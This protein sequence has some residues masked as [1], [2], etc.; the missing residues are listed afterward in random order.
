MRSLLFPL[1]LALLL[2]PAPLAQR[3]PAD[4]GA[5]PSR[6]D[7]LAPTRIELAGKALARFPYFQYTRSFNQGEPIQIA[8]DPRVER[9][10]VRRTLDV[11]LI[12]HEALAAHLAGQRFEGPPLRV[13]LVSAL[14]RDNIF[15]LDAGTLSGASKAD[16]QGTRVLGRGYDLAVDVDADGRLGAGDLLDGSLDEAGFYVLEDFVD[17]RAADSLE[18]GPYAVSEVLFEGGTNL[19]RQDVYFP[20]EIGLLGALPLIVVSHGN[21]HFYTWYDHIGYHLASWGYVVMSHVNNTGP[22]IETAS[23]TTLQNTELFFARLGEIADG[24]L[25]G[26]VDVHRQVWIGH[27]RGG[28]GVVRAYRRLEL[29]TPLVT[30][31]TLADVKLVSSIAPTD[32]LGPNASNMGAAS[33]HLWTGGADA[34][35]NGCA[36]C[37]ICQTFHLLERAD[38]TRFSSS[39]H[40]AGHGDFHAGGGSSVAAGPCLLGRTT[41]HTIMRALLLPLVQVA[42]HANPAALDYLTRQWEEFRATGAPG[43]LDN[44]CVSVDLQYV[45]GPERER[46]VIDDFQSEPLRTRSSSGGG[47][48][49]SPGLEAH[50]EEGRFDDRNADF[51]TVTTDGMNGMTLAGPAD[52]SAG[53]VFDWNGTDETLHFELIEGARDLGAWRTLSFRGAQATRH[54][55]TTAELGDLDFAVQVVDSALHTSTLQLSAYGA[56]LEEPYQRG[57]CGGGGGVGW[58]NEFETFRIPLGDFRRGGRRIDLA[59]VIG[60]GFLFGPAHGSTSGRIGLDEI[61]LTRD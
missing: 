22:G 20:R 1:P 43:P 39:L 15:L 35:V 19:T 18:T 9:A 47:V 55:N 59:N 21:G 53:I 30:Q 10:L 49:I 54:P 25:L 37:N 38:G 36:N 23:T 50:Y 6:A 57:G 11:Y 8:F 51:N 31:Y 17:F 28:E 41:T 4:A 26:H 48:L 5:F 2:A 52:D 12:E 13:Q 27:S 45:P 34:D 29:G 33:Y 56:G 46:L 32:F 7:E 44:A 16:E 58:G 60:I 40:G 14:V 3:S 42:V 61:M 24:A